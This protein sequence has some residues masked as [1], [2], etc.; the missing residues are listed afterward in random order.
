MIQYW[1]LMALRPGFS[2]LNT[3]SAKKVHSLYKH[4]KTEFILILHI[5]HITSWRLKV[6]Y[7]NLCRRKIVEQ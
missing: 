5:G 7:W 4:F 3:I 2:T 6:G 1:F